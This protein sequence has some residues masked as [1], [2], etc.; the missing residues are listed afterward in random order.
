M[1]A[2]PAEELISDLKASAWEWGSL[3]KGRRDVGR[4]SG[5][6]RLFMHAA[7]R[8]SYCLGLLTGPAWFRPRS[9]AVSPPCVMFRPCSRNSSLKERAR[10]WTSS[11]SPIPDAL[12]SFPSSTR[13]YCMW[14]RAVVSSQSSLL[15]VGTTSTHT[16]RVARQWQ[17][18]EMYK[19]AVASHWTA[20]EIDLAHDRKV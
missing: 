16:Q 2:V 8:I 7:P 15:S 10:R 18:W 6:S 12:C 11:W 19:K 9:P 13:R 20:E 14:G 3:E 5:R 17:V 4:V 1:A